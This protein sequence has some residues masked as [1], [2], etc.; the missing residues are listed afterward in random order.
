[1]KDR[2]RDEE[3]S[4]AKADGEKERGEAGSDAQHVGMVRANPKFTPEAS[5]IRLFGPGV[6]DDTKA[7][8]IRRGYGLGSRCRFP[9]RGIAPATAFGGYIPC[10]PRFIAATPV[11]QISTSRVAA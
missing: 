1:M 4:E 6:I 5:N 11:R 10:G 3:S 7:K 2:K 8:T 9:S